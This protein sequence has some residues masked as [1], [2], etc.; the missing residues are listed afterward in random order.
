ML[1]IVRKGLLGLALLAT[2]GSTV[3]MADTPSGKPAAVC[4]QQHGN[5]LQKLNLTA[6]QQSQ[7]HGF[8]QQYRTQ[9][10]ADRQAFEG[11]LKTVLNQDQWARF[12]AHQAERP[13]GADKMGHRRHH[14]HRLAFL[15]LTPEQKAQ[16][17]AY[18]ETQR[19]QQQAERQQLRSRIRGVLTPDQQAVFDQMQAQRQYRHTS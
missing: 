8:M 10:K 14:H 19:P 13:A 7:V 17:Q 12:Q 18:R 3:A 5:M 11:E 1:N 2:V 9:K 4:R 6:D 15:N 16:L